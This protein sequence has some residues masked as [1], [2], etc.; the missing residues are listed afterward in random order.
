MCVYKYELGL[1]GTRR[2]DGQTG[3]FEWLP[4]LP[5]SDQSIS[6]DQ[7]RWGELCNCVHYHLVEMLSDLPQLFCDILT[8]LAYY[9]N[10]PKQYKS[11]KV[12]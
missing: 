11:A 5:R 7:L 9:T 4:L 3:G 12:R 10:Q 1:G 8:I 6:A 2:G